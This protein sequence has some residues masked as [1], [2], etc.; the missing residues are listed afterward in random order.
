MKKT[1]IIILL[2]FSPYLLVAQQAAFDSL[3]QKYSGKKGYTTMEMT[4]ELI[5]MA[6]GKSAGDDGE[7][8]G[9][10]RIWI[11]MSNEASEEFTSDVKKLTSQNNLKSITSISRDK[12]EVKMFQ[13]NTTSQKGGTTKS[14]FIMTVTGDSTNIAIRITGSFDIN[15]IPQLNKIRRKSATST[16]LSNDH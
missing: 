13:V 11:V 1:I 3:F 8:T 9:I 16:T 12:E 6:F 4:G 7:F 2:L 5:Q 14:E 10:E 15:K